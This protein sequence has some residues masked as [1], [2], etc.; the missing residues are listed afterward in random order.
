[1]PDVVFIGGP[2]DGHSDE[3]GQCRPVDELAWLVGRDVFRLFAGAEEKTR[4]TITSVAIY[5]LDVV[6]GQFQYHFSHA[7][8]FNELTEEMLVKRS[9]QRSSNQRAGL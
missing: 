9:L 4:G 2:Y 1:M 3:L 5:E 7:I 6:D 8:S